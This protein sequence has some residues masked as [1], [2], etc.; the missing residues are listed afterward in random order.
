MYTVLIDWFSISI[1]Y[2]LIHPL[3]P[4]L[5]H[6]YPAHPSGGNNII[7]PSIVRILLCINELQEGVA[8]II[9]EKL[10]DFTTEEPGGEM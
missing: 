4:H 8:K 10:L 9:I 7:L 3:R 1:L 5:L 2:S 6:L